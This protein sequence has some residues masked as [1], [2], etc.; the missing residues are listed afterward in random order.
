M[1]EFE[2][3]D[4]LRV[5]RKEIKTI[6][7][8]TTF[9]QRI[10]SE[11]N[12]GYGQSARAIAQAS[13]ATFYYLA[14]KMGITGYQASCA[15]WDVIRDVNYTDNKCGM[16]LVDYD[17]MLFPQYDYVFE[18]KI[19]SD[20]WEL[21]QSQAKNNLTRNLEFCHDAVVNHWENIAN[22]MVP[23]GYVVSDD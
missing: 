4:K 12:T 8:L 3:R 21:L 19:S 6:D 20:T 9:I 18:K 5:E 11:C 16:K 14:G 22:G 7:D 10:E 2:L 23:F 17:K 13:V 15:L 1:D